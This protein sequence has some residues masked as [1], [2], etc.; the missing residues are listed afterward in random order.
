[1][2]LHGMAVPLVAAEPALGPDV[3]VGFR[4][5]LHLDADV[6]RHLWA[7]WGLDP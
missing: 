4:A 2:A 7:A 5:A 6:G 3:V 1:V